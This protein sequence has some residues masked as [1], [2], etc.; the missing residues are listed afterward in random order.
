[1]IYF[2]RPLI[3]AIVP[4]LSMAVFWNC[5]KPNKKL[6]LDPDQK[7]LEIFGN[8]QQ[9]QSL[10]AHIKAMNAFGDSADIYF[11][12]S[13]SRLRADSTIHIEIMNTYQR[14]PENLYFAKAHLIQTLSDLETDASLEALN[15]IASRVPGQEKSRN[16][17]YSTRAQESIISTTATEGISRLAVKGNETAYR[18]LNELVKS[19]DITVRQ[20][21]IRGILTSQLGGD[22]KSKADQLRKILP[23]EQH[24]MITSERTDIRTV[25]HP[26]MPS[27]FKFDRN[28][29]KDS[30]KLKKQ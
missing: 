22:E 19:E 9:A 14:V 15:S 16:P 8:S 27:E 30:P 17:E 25:P 26:D 20:M 29:P 1:M 2:P 12:E 11:K 24:W 18:Y 23:Q 28:A 4:I 21:A 6:L 3:I 5:T 13:L 7:Q 10:Q